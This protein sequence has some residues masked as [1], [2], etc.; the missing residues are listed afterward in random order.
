M[1]IPGVEHRPQTSSFQ[2]QE[3]SNTQ[4]DPLN[5]DCEGRMR[6]AVSSIR[7]RFALRKLVSQSM[8]ELRFAFVPVPW[9]LSFE[10][11]PSRSQADTC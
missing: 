10:A 1:R 9:T 4:H 6:P 7:K 2:K 5:S 11:L 3:S 8:L